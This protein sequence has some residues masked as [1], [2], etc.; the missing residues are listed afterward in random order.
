MTLVLSLYDVREADEAQ[1]AHIGAVKAA[2]VAARVCL[3]CYR[4]EICRRQAGCQ[5][6]LPA[7][8]HVVRDARHV[9]RDGGRLV[10]RMRNDL[11]GIG[12]EV[13]VSD[14]LG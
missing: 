9:D 12:V 11:D 8:G 1:A 7:V 3:I 13:I 4:P 5:V 2:V 6:V 10:V 14:G